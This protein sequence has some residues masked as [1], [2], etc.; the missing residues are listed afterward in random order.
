[1][2]AAPTEGLLW[3]KDRIHQESPIDMAMPWMSYGAI[4][5]LDEKVQRGWR[6]FEWGGGGST[7]FFLERGCKVTTVESSVH[8]I[9]ELELAANNIG[10]LTSLEIRYIE[11]ETMSKEAVDEYVA[12]VHDGQPWDLVIVDGLE[13]NYITRVDCIKELA[14]SVRP[15]GLVVLD[16]SWRDQYL[17]VPEILKRWRRLIFRGLGP[18][19]LGVTQTDIY[20]APSR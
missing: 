20:V 19:R 1:M 7:I 4:N 3:I 15:G 12:S 17:Q 10:G 8:W 13:E 18:A 16:D 2:V 5:Y 11:A 14:G 9:G 6:V